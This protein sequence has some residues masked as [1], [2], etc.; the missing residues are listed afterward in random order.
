MKLRAVVT[1]LAR[2]PPEPIIF[3][4]FSA[5]SFQ[6]FILPDYIYYTSCIQLRGGNCSNILNQNQTVPCGNTSNS[7]IDSIQ[8]YSSYLSLVAQLL[9]TVPTLLTIF[10]AGALS[11]VIGRKLILITALV[12]SILSSVIFLLI[13]LFKLHPYFILLPELVDGLGG[14]HQ[15]VTIAVSSMVADLTTHKR[16]TFRLSIMEACILMGTFLFQVLS[17]YLLNWVGFLWSFVIV[18]V[19]YVVTLLY[20][21]CV[22]ESLSKAAK[23]PS[24]T[25]LYKKTK[26]TL[27][28]CVTPLLLFVRNKDRLKFAVYLVVFGF[29]ISDVVTTL[30]IFPLYALAPP[31]CWGTSKQGWYLGLTYLARC[32]GLYLFLP[33]LFKCGFPDNLLILIGIL[34]SALVYGLTG[35]LNTD[36]GLLG[37]VP[38]VALLASIGVPSI[39][40]SLSKLVLPSEHGSLFS[41][42]SFLNAVSSILSIVVFNSLYPTLRLINPSWIFYVVGG[43]TVLPALA[44]VLLMGYGFLTGRRKKES[45]SVTDDDQLIN[46]TQEVDSDNN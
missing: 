33:F 26:S 20:I 19:M 15:S 34:D 35:A 9:Y 31:L 30:S 41:I 38:A 13:S 42:I 11:D 1:S 21:L 10:I 32:I 7:S 40:S 5:L 43:V 36:W 4:Y 25:S 14:N 12:A 28:Q 44:V 24:P 29:I 37:V 18:I 39:R 2:L 23:P 46:E 22:P 27:K 17:G 6:R 8:A 3:L 16:R 45:V